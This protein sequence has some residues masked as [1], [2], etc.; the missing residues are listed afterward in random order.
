MMWYTN[1][2][3]WNFEWFGFGGFGMI[4][5]LAFMF[6]LVFAVVYTLRWIFTFSRNY[7][8]H[9][10]AMEILMKRYLSGDIDED[11]FERMRKKI[12]HFKRKG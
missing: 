3:R 10:D 4:V 5:G 6:L 8:S 1:P 9:E 12:E 7:Y 2:W 11:E